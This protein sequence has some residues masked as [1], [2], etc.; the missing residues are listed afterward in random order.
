MP[1]ADSAAT[2]LL[3]LR[4][5]TK[6]FESAAGATLALRNVT[7]EIA[8]GSFSL[9]TGP[10][11]SGKTTLLHIATLLE[12]PS[13]G[14]VWFDGENTAGLDDR[15]RAARRA[16][17]IGMIFQRFHLLPHRSA[18]DN[19]LFRFRYA[20]RPRAEEN[21]LAR[22]ALA[23][24]GLAHRARQRARLLSGGEMQRAAIA[25]AIAW[26]PL[27]LAADEPT[28]NLDRAAAE[29]V[30]DCLHDLNRQGVTVLLATHNEALIRPG[31]R[32]IRLEDG[33]L[34]PAAT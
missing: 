9:L 24:V 19:V 28:G 25:R 14:E 18:L 33:Q 13:E 4:S 7:L 20:P 30:M 6:R 10:S 27:L 29:G 23:R 8:R 22:A 34:R 11:G 5:V 32:H 15:A 21:A 16:A 2:P 26:P 12:P 31:D 17:K 1:A 3:A